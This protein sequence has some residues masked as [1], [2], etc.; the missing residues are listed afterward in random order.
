MKTPLWPARTLNGLLVLAT[1]AGM[2]SCTKDSRNPEAQN[3]RV[4]EG[5]DALFSTGALKSSPD[6]L[7]S[8]E[9]FRPISLEILARRGKP[10]TGGS[11]T[12]PTNPAT[13]TDPVTPTT[14]TTPTTP[15][16]YPAAYSLDMPVPGTQGGEGSCTAW[17]TTYGA[18]SFLNRA[19]NAPYGTG[20]NMLSPEYVYNQTKF[21]TSATDCVS[22]AYITTVLNLLTSQGACTWDAMPYSSANG[23]STMPNAT[24]QSNA[25]SHKLH[26]YNLIWASYQGSSSTLITNIKNSIYANKPV[27]IGLDVYQNFQTLGANQVFTGNSGAYKGGHSMV[28]CGW[29]D[30]LQAFKVMN[31]WGTGWATGGFGY[32]SYAA[33]P[34]VAWEA[35]S[36]Y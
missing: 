26:G 27:V 28:V 34:S 7:Q 11:T 25:N 1:V 17:S 5:T 15:A 21:S 35:Y 32:I 13:P 36:L 3:V 20:T 24:Q 18:L 31:S 9:R 8:V 22:G 16:A 10:S 30:N 33:F 14:P 2:A 19:G 12:T 4:N 6:Q 29:D 23:C